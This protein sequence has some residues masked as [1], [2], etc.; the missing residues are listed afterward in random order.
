MHPIFHITVDQI[1]RLNDGQ[2]RELI[3]RLSR[4]HL[5][6]AGLDSSSVQWGGDQRAADGGID[7]LI[8][9]SPAVDM[10]GPLR[11]SAGIIQVKAETFGPAK[12]GPEMADRKSVV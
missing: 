7:V 10:D 2:A 6:R 4:A 12:I 9:H 8:E 1:R 3:A 5:Q 11:R